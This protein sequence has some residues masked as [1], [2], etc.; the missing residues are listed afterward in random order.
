MVEINTI[1][2]KLKREELYKKEKA[3]KAKHKRDRR[4]ALS[5]EESSNPEKK[6][7]RLADKVPNTLENTREFDETI[8]EEDEEVAA[9]EAT[10]EFAK[11]FQN[12]LA[13]KILITTSKGPSLVSLLFF[14][15]KP[16]GLLFSEGGV[17]KSKY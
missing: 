8:V 9:D 17:F 10:D 5:K 12:G 16:R 1:K 2:N 7:K 14:S 4:M 15:Q 11:Y 13:P 6:E 3:A